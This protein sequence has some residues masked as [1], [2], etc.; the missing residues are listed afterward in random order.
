MHSGIAEKASGLSAG[1]IV[2]RA[3]VLKP[4]CEKLFHIKRVITFQSY[5][6]YI[7]ST[8]LRLSILFRNWHNVQ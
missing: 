2:R 6:I 3:T 8:S 5:R 4:V 7:S 1:I